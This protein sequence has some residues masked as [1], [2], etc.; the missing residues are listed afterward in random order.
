MKVLLIF[1]FSISTF[2]SGQTQDSISVKNSKPIKFTNSI[3]VGVDLFGAGKSFFTDNKKYSAMLTTRVY[4]NLHLAFEV[5]NQSGIYDDLDWKMKGEGMFYKVGVNYFLTKRA[6][7]KHDGFYIG[8]K[9]AYS[10]FNQT[11]EQYPIRYSYQSASFGS[12]SKENTYAFWLEFSAG[13]RVQ[14]GNSNFY[15]LSELQPKIVLSANNQNDIESLFIPGLGKNSSAIN[16]D[17]FTGIAY[18]F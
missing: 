8:G 1:L 13:A 4:K 12:I 10:N 15:L 6:K 5:G 16:F 18:K 9:F 11:I 2:L 3:F 17:L 14:I 7:N